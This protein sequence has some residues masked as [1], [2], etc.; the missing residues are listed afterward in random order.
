LQAVVANGCRGV[1]SLIHVARF[2]QSL[3]L[4]VMRPD[5]SVEIRL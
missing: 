2:K 1:Q 3:P 5:A 4:N